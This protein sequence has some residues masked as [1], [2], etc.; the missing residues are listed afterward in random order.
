M[1]EATIITLLTINLVVLSVVIITLIIVAIVLV[2]KLNK[3][4][5]NVQQTTANVASITDWF[6][7]V[8]IFKEIA[9]AINSMK[10]R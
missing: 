1:D 8:K 9:A 3:I 7:P 2:V 10:K 4:A 6:S 5:S